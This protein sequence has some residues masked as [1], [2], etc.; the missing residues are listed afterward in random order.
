MCVTWRDADAS[1]PN[2]AFYEEEITHRIRPMDTY[3]LLVKQDAD[4]VT[5]MTEF[6]LEDDGKKVFR[7]KTTIPAS[8][9]EKIEILAEP[10]KPR[11]RKPKPLDACPSE[12]QTE[13]PS[14]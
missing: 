8:L 6:Y 12:P 5:V 2:E 14:R 7:G 9:I 1:A 4:G 3:G 11:S 10:W 13:D